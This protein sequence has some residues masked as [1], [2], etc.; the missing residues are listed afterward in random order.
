MKID[1][2]ITT[3][4]KSEEK[5]FKKVTKTLDDETMVKQMLKA[6]NMASAIWGITQVLRSRVK[7]PDDSVTSDTLDELYNVKDAVHEILEANK[8]DIDELYN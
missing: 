2:T 6:S 5:L 1:I 7:Y 4:N 3:H 8:I